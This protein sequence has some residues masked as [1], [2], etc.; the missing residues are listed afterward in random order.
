MKTT[1]FLAI[2][3]IAVVSVTGQVAAQE[4]SERSSDFD[5]A[6]N[7]KLRIVATSTGCDVVCESVGD[8]GK[9]VVASQTQSVVYTQ[10]E[11]QSTEKI[12]QGKHIAKATITMKNSGSGAGK[13]NLQDFHFAVQSKGRVIPVTVDNDTCTFPDDL[14]DGTYDVVCSWSWGA[15]QSGASSQKSID[16]HIK[17]INGVCEN[18]AINEK[19]TAGTKSPK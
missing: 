15:S 18:M 11:A 3:I 13:V 9:N 14:P 7:V 17:L 5:L 1:N 12:V 19:G 16:C 8:N 6:K 2:A 4:T 10:D